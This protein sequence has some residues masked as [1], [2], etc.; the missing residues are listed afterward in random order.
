MKQHN[1]FRGICLL[2]I[3]CL[4]NCI[5]PAASYAQTT[6]LSDYVM[7]SGN[8]GAGTTAPGSSGYGVIFG[9]SSTITGGAIGSF[10]LVQTTGGA[11]L[12]TNIYSGGKVIL[13]NGNS[14]S[15]RITAQNTSSLSG[16]ILSAGSNAVLSGILDVNGN[17]V[18]QSG[19]V[20]GPVHTTGTYTGPAPTNGVNNSPS[21]PVL[22]TFPA[23]IVFPPAG[24]T[25]ITTTT[26]LTPGSY[27]NITLTNNKT[28]TFN[29][30]R[31]SVV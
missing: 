31:K 11:N 27:G 13:A 26:T 25:N 15:G 9:S 28:I 24:V 14:V 17:V 10:Y 23:A 20:S 1:F 8:G 30:D 19:T 12:S 29:G 4:I 18:V 22:P 7:F 6:V 3:A 21:F 16:T 2:G 5:L